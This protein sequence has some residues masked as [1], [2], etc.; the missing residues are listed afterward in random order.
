MVQIW[1]INL[2]TAAHKTVDPREFAIQ[3]NIVG[4]GWAVEGE[5]NDWETYKKLGN[6]TY[7]NRG[8]KGWWPAINAI[9]NRM[10]MND[11][12]W[13]RDSKGVYYLGRII[14][15]WAYKTDSRF[16]KADMVNSRKCDW[17]KVGTVDAIPGKVVNSFIA[18]RTVQQIHDKTIRDFSMFLY[19]KHH[20]NDIYS[21]ERKEN[22]IYSF[23][24]PDDCEDVIG[25]Y[26]QFKHN[27]MLVPSSCKSNT[28]FYEYVLLH[29]ETYSPAIVQ[30]KNGDV[31]LH[32]EDY[33]NPNEQDVYLFTTKGKYVGRER[34]YIHCLCPDD[35]KRFMFS[36]SS[37]LPKKVQ[38]WIE[39]IRNIK[40]AT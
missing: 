5:I 1:R 32:I 10:K 29:K 2:K 28:M 34:S 23:L 6:E 8:D 16:V 17:I 18:R 7:A 33:I 36:Y 11:L 37:V 35:I 9:K 15:D 24:S 3:E 27:Y 22:D 30:V 12:C 19:N 31:H 20:K 14:G 21:T 39:F 4:I 38:F 25:I 26:L 13:T 40:C